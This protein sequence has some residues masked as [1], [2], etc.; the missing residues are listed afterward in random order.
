MKAKTFYLFDQTSSSY[1]YR[2]HH[3]IFTNQHYVE[4]LFITTILYLKIIVSQ[5]RLIRH[6]FI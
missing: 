1:M 2:K 5:Y 4:P 6:V 3:I